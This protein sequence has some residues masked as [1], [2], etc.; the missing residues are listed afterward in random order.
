MLSPHWPLPWGPLSGSDEERGQT[1]LSLGAG[2]DV[3]GLC[4]GR[5]TISLSRILDSHPRPQPLPAPVRPG[6]HTDAAFL[7]SH[8]LQLCVPSPGFSERRDSVS[9]LLPSVFTRAWAGNEG[10]R[11]LVSSSC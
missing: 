6:D 2:T 9:S 5:G 7:C 3:T 10:Q 4:T 8:W 11:V 1:A